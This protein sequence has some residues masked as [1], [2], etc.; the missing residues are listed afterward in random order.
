MTANENPMICFSESSLTTNSTPKPFRSWRV[1]RTLPVSIDTLLCPAE[2]RVHHHARAMPDVPFPGS[3][4]EKREERA[5]ARAL[6]PSITHPQISYEGG[7]SVRARPPPRPKPPRL[8]D[9]S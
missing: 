6:R 1:G 4:S 2:S 9:T 5:R 8:L 7:A 3:P